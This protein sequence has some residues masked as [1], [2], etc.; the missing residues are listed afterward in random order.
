[1][2]QPLLGPAP[3]IVFTG[4]HVAEIII[5]IL[6]IIKSTSDAVADP[7]RRVGVLIRAKEHVRNIITAGAV[8]HA[9]IVGIETQYP[10]ELVPGV[11]MKLVVERSILFKI[12]SSKPGSG[13]Q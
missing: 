6:F 7:A 2:R 12:W 10:V 4:L 11:H 13:C 3:V 5:N 8:K 9:G 1:M